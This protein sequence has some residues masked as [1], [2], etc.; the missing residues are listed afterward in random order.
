MWS[1]GAAVLLSACLALQSVSALRIPVERRRISKAPLLSEGLHARDGGNGTAGDTTM[2]NFY[3]FSYVGNITV[4][5]VEYQLVL[6]KRFSLSAF[7]MFI[8]NGSDIDTGRHVYSSEKMDV[9]YPYNGIS[10]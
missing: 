10:H 9:L 6:G 1:L 8:I 3:D 2:K 5:G 4:G 7:H